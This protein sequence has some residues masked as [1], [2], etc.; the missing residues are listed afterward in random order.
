MALRWYVV[1]VY[2]GFEKKVAQAIQEQ[3]DKVVLLID[4]RKYL[5]LRKK[6]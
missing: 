4:L 5:S 2:S 1:N 6:W 3:A